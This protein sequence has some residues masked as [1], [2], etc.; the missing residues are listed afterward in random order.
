MKR[1][2]VFIGLAWGFWFATVQPSVVSAAENG[3]GHYSPGGMASF[4]DVA[5]PGFAVINFF[6]YYNGSAGGERQLPFGGLI[7][8]NLDVTTYADV[9]GLAYKTPFG[10]LDGTFNVAVLVPY[11]WAEVEADVDLNTRPPRPGRSISKRDKAEGIGDIT[12]IPFWLAWNKGDFK[13]DARLAIY[14]PTGDFTKGQLANV[15]LNYWTF[16]PVVSFSYLSSKIGLEVSAFAG[17]DF[18]TENDAT[19]YQS[20]DVLHLDLTVAE[21]LPGRPP[22]AT[23]SPTT[24]GGWPRAAWGRSS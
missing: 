3:M 9:I 8:A 20:G 24:A 18:N 13:W 14:A 1:V 21:H 10:I 12:L 16:E 15:G 22:F 2:M 19:D 7:A 23:N 4:I 5:P 11:I 6:N 17:L